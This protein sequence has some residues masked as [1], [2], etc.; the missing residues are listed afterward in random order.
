VRRGRGG[1]DL[2]LG[3]FEVGR[4]LEPITA[5]KVHG[6]KIENG[7]CQGQRRYEEGMR[8][9]GHLLGGGGGSG[10]H[11]QAKGSGGCRR[12]RRGED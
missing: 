4:G 8:K 7:S 3:T 6:S 10:S 9:L 2:A 1:R 12:K 5:Q 11:W